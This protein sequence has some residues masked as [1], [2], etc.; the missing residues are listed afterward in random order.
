MENKGED[1]HLLV[2][3]KRSVCVLFVVRQ[4]ILLM[5]LSSLLLGNITTVVDVY[6]EYGGY[7]LVLLVMRMLV[8]F[9][10]P[11]R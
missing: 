3:L 8:L 11:T 5:V 10:G 9:C 6:K 7:S 4:A 1:N 2:L